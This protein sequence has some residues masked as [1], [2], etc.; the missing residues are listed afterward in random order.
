MIPR[1]RILRNRPARVIQARQ[2]PGCYGYDFPDPVHVQGVEIRRQE[3]GAILELHQV[4]GLVSS[5][6]LPLGAEIE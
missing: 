2:G 1:F 6:W 5:L 4:D 3:H